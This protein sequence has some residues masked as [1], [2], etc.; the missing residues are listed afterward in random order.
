MP[1]KLTG[2]I[3]YLKIRNLYLL[4]LCQLVKTLTDILFWFLSL[5]LSLYVPF[6]DYS[7]FLIPGNTNFVF[8]MLIPGN[9]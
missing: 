2:A 3:S 4:I 7:G 5:F 8:M 9:Q 6:T 1:D